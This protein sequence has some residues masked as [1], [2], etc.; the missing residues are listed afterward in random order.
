MQ[1]L[2]TPLLGRCQLRRDLERREVGQGAPDTM[3]FRLELGGSGRQGRSGRL[4]AAQPLQRVAQQLLAVV[5]IGS[6][7]GCHEH[8]GLAR[9]QAVPF[10]ARE[11]RVL[12]GLGQRCERVRLR[13]PHGAASH[14]LFDVRRQPRADRLATLNPIRLAPDETGHQ[15]GRQAIVLE[16]RADHARLVQRRNGARGRVDG[17]H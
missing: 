11:Q 7:P 13:R 5:R 10:H 12:L 9:T 1:R 16:Q 3:Q 15:R 6:A 17:E 8:Q 2:K 4:L 14:P